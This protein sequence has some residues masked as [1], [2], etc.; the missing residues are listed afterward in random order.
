MDNIKEWTSLSMPELLTVA[1]RGKVWKTIS[2]ESS[3][4]SPDDQIFQESELNLHLSCR[5]TEPTQ[6][7]VR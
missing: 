2:A 1:S 5:P 4:M 6:I 3:F 7:T